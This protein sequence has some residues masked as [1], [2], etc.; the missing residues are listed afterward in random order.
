MADPS[1]STSAMPLDEIQWHTNPAVVGGSIHDNSVLFYFR[2]SPFYDKTSN[3]EVL[4]QQ[5]LHNQTMMQFLETRERFERRLREMSGLEF[6]VAQEPAETAP[7]TGTGVWVINK[8]TRRKRQGE[9]DEIS[10]HGTYFL[11]GENVYMAPTLA[12]II[13]MRLASAS[14]SISRLLPIAASVQ[15][16]SPGTGRVYKTPSMTSQTN[17][18]NQP[19]SQTQSQPTSQPATT[20]TTTA[21]PPPDP[22]WLEETLMIHETFGDHH[23]DKNPITGKPGDFHLSS[24]G[25]KIQ[26]LPTAAAGNKKPGSGLPPLPAINTKVQQN[27]MGS[28]KQ[29]TGKETKSPKTPSSSTGPG[30]GGMSTGMGKPK[31]R[32][33]S[34]AAV[35]PTS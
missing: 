4:Y 25:R 28:G 13:S 2:E 35:T 11:V 17:Q 16:W 14:S 24:T 19:S 32:K 8:Q 22:R 15:S 34:K 9:E 1:S 18:A 27:P 23:L 3:N 20:T 31:K 10:V 29:V 21:L 6:V 26:T 30:T 33:S 5:G 7:G 12:D